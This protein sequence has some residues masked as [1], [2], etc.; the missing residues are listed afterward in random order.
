MTSRLALGTA[1]FGLVY[2]VANKIGKVS[3]D[4]ICAILALAEESGIDTVDTAMLYGDSERVLGD[5]G[6]K[7]WRVF[8][9]V[10][11]APLADGALAQWMRHQVEAS[12]KRL[13]IGR[14]AGLMLH[15]PAQLLGTEG[16]MLYSAMRECRSAGLVGKIGYSVYHPVELNRIFDRFPPDIV[17]LPMNIADRRFL[18][19]GWLSRLKSAGVEVHARSAFLQGL[20]LMN[21]SDRPR[22]FEPWHSLWRAWDDWL[23]ECSLSPLHAAISYVLEHPQIDRVVVGV[24]SRAQLLEIVDAAAKHAPPPPASLSCEDEMLINPG[25]WSQL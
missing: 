9:K 4:E 19:S 25:M 13:G 20:L 18:N 16:D 1:Q 14:L 15:R 2:G 17:Q 7:K 22:K 24:D 11:E 23:D 10:P 6:V 21:A 3:P 12:I 8:T 5:A